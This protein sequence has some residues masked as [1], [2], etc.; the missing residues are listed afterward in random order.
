MERFRISLE[1]IQVEKVVK[2]NKK[3]A[4]NYAY[5]SAKNSASDIMGTPKFSALVF[6][7][8]PI[9]SPAII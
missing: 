8:G 2:L 9:L 1:R 7:L 5:T 3:V 4:V 6:L